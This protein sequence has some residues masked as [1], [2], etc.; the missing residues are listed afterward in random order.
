MFY[1]QKWHFLSTKHS[2]NN[3]NRSEFKASHICLLP[4]LHFR[5]PKILMPGEPRELLYFI[6]FLAAFIT[7]GNIQMKQGDSWA[8]SAFHQPQAAPKAHQGWHLPRQECS[9]YLPSASGMQFPISCSALPLIPSFVWC[10]MR[11]H[12]HREQ[13]MKFIYLFPHCKRA[14]K[15]VVSNLCVWSL[16][17]LFIFLIWKHSFWR[18]GVCEICSRSQILSQWNVRKSL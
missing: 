12:H 16:H 1:L 3:P 14:P 10:S 6:F 11:C 5:K 18:S 7:H 17:F 13:L 8:I 2:K 9:H 4:S 15:M